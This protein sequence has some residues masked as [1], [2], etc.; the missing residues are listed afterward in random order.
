MI[1]VACIILSDSR[2]T[3]AKRLKLKIYF[4]HLVIGAK[5]VTLTVLHGQGLTTHTGSGLK[6]R[7]HLIWLTASLPD[8][9]YHYHSSL[10]RLTLNR[11]TLHQAHCCCKT[12]WVFPNSP[13]G[14]PLP[15]HTETNGTKVRKCWC[16]QVEKTSPGPSYNPLSPLSPSFLTSFNLSLP[17]SINTMSPPPLGNFPFGE[18]TA[19]GK[20]VL[21]SVT[22]IAVAPTKQFA[23]LLKYYRN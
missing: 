1:F 2:W 7:T 22:V 16:N 17:P 18:L 14:N 20:L 4:Y 23:Y 11:F 10:C 5:S 15:R 21:Y 12:P 8:T 6:W 3:F 13:A 9:S 19:T